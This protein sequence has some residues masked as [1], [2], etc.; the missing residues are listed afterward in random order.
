MR[1]NVKI[2]GILTFFEWQIQYLRVWK[3]EKSLF[4]SIL[5]SRNRWNF[6]LRWVDM[7]ML[8]WVEHVKSSIT[9]EPDAFM[10]LW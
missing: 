3:Q 2:L 9:S 6:M 1:L 10:H 5:V 8:S 7:G 4:F